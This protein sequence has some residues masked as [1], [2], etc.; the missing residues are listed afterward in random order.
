M[1]WPTTE[2]QLLLVIQEK[3]SSVWSA[4]VILPFLLNGNKQIVNVIIV[5]RT[6]QSRWWLTFHTINIIFCLPWFGCC[7]SI[8][9]N[10]SNLLVEVLINWR[11]QPSPFHKSIQRIKSLKMNTEEWL[12]YC[13]YWN[14]LRKGIFFVS[15]SVLFFIWFW[16]L[17][18]S[19][20]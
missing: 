15:I 6:K 11:R 3:T 19:C 12:Y 4:H 7:T 10:W 20:Q 8:Y 18:I 1:L 14:V 5:N 2:P 16:T 13:D 17:I 9:R